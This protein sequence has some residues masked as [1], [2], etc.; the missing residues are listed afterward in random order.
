MVAPAVVDAVAP[1]IRIPAI[2]ARIN[3][4]IFIISNRE[5]T[6]YCK[7]DALMIPA[8]VPVPIRRI[9]TPATLL[10]PNSANSRNCTRLPHAIA[11]TRPPSGRAINGS[12]TIENIGR[13]A[14]S[15]ITVSGPANA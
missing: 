6:S 5:I 3:A 12:I 2:G 9:D 8:I 14:N 10:R 15:I 1:A 7:A 11:H 4:G 13:S